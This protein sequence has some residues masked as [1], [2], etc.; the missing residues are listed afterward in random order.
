MSEIKGKFIVLAV[1]GSVAAVRAFDLCRELV[2][3]GAKVQV[4]M[5][6][7]AT[8]LISEDLMQYASGRKVIT[9]LSGRVEHVKLLGIKGKA[10]LLL[11]APATANTISKIA[12]GIDDTPITTLATTA[13]GSKKPVLIVPAMHYSMWEH[14]IVEE[15]LQKLKEKNRVKIIEPVIAEN[16]AKIAGIDIVILEIERALSKQKLKGKKVLVCSG[17]TLEEIDPIRVLTSKSSGKT[18]IELAKEA[19]RKG[20][21]VTVIALQGVGNGIR[22]IE[23]KSSSEMI[24]ETLLE[25]KRGYDMFICAAAISDFTVRKSRNKI[26]SNKGIKLE[27]IPNRKLIEIARKEFPG[28]FIVGFKAETNVSDEKLIR[29]GKKFLKKNNLQMVVANDVGKRG[30]GTEENKV[31]II[32]SKGKPKKVKGSK[33]IIAG[34]IVSAASNQLPKNG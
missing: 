32:A 9:K 28:L 21:K 13:I 7:A 16:K 15:N 22:H 3:K 14:P 29:E 10:D 24:G 17:P 8:K 12:M 30:I 31:F 2:R 34:R 19:Y 27:L 33:E 11:I 25:L 20:A 4:V 18:G 5:S 6:E 23:V 26:K 1:C